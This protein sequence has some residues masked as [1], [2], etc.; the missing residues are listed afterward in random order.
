MKK[1]TLYRSGIAFLLITL[2]LFATTLPAQA[3]TATENQNEQAEELEYQVVTDK[4]GIL[5]QDQI[6]SIEAKVGELT[7]IDAAV[8]VEMVDSKTCNQKYANT[9]SE[10]VYTEVFG[11]GYRNGIMI[12]FSFYKEANCY[13][14]VHYGGNVEL[15]ES[16]VSRIIEGTYH[17]FKTDATWIEGS[18]KQCVD[19]FKTLTLSTSGG[20]NENTDKEGLPTSTAVFI[21]LFIIA[22]FVIIFLIWKLV[23]NRREAEDT[24]SE[25]KKEREAVYKMNSELKAKKSELEGRLLRLGQKH[26]ALDK[27]QKNALQVH[28]NLQEEIDD[29]LARREAKEFDEHF[30]NAINLDAIMENFQTFDSMVRNYESMNDLAKSYVTL[31]M[32]VASEKHQKSGEAYA[33]TATKKIEGVCRKCTGSRHDRDELN[34]T[35]SYYNGLPMFVRMMI[36]SQLV[37]SLTSKRDHAESAQRSYQNS[38]NNYYHNSSHHYG[39]TF[40]G[41]FHGGGTFGGHVGGGH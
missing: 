39:G 36:A 11:E 25:L 9:L 2:V 30:S 40:G 17:D 37:R 7:E 12:V 28:T 38:Q 3:T 32:K 10:S 35:Y 21:V 20:E 14:A 22:I 31:D 1:L 8:Y 4:W 23:S 26:D 13:Y 15:S 27:W 24:I 6:S 16:K 5:T 33:E 41:G 19:Y 18:F 34:K 29:M